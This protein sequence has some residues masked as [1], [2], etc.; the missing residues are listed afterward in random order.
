[1]RS[2]RELLWNLLDIRLSAC[3]GLH[4]DNQM[5]GTHSSIGESPQNELQLYPDFPPKGPFY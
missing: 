2:Q 1:M 3:K 5:Q 4:L